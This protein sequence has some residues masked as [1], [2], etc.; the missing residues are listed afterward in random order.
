LLRQ[1]PDYRAIFAP[2]ERRRRPAIALENGQPP[3]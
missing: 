3:T 2:E 1:S